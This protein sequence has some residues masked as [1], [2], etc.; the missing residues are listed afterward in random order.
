LWTLSISQSNSK[1]RELEIFR[2]NVFCAID[3]ESPSTCDR[4]IMDMIRMHDTLSRELRE[5]PVSESGQ[6]RFYVCGPTVYGPAHIGNFITF[7]RFD[8]L[9]RLLKLAGYG[10]YYVRNITDVDDKTIRNAVES[11]ES[12]QAFT[13]KWT[14]HFHEDCQKLNMLDPDVEPRAT[15]HIEEQID[16]VETLVEKRHA[17]VGGD[18]SV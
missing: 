9:Y 14:Q 4:R 18:G 13:E 11:G 10:P 2:L 15:A 12:L 3:L 1:G 8:V 17:Y 7:V 6:F 16:M 5:L